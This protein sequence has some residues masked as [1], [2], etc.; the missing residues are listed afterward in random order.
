MFTRSQNKTRGNEKSTSSTWVLKFIS[1]EVL[2]NSSPSFN[3]LLKLLPTKVSKRNIFTSFFPPRST[4]WQQLDVAL[5]LPPEENLTLWVFVYLWNSYLYLT[6]SV[7]VHLFIVYLYIVYLCIC[8]SPCEYLWKKT[9]CLTFCFTFRFPLMILL[10]QICYLWR[11]YCSSGTNALQVNACFL[12]KTIKF[13][14]M[15][16]WHPTKKYFWLFFIMA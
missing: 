5:L 3:N 13:Y 7:F 11:S 10:L 12:S 8:T 2:N 9:R 14:F 16:H 1:L 4:N 15:V 6:L